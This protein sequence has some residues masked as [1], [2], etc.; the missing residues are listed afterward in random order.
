[1]DGHAPEFLPGTLW[2]TA[3]VD[4]VAGSIRL[5][6]RAVPA[7]GDVPPDSAVG[8][9]SRRAKRGE[10]GVQL[11]CVATERYAAL[12]VFLMPCSTGVPPRGSY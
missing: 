8:L 7:L 4:R 12:A 3:L 2:L 9:S 5:P 11:L 1:M 10:T 6:L